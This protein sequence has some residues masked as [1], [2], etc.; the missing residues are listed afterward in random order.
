MDTQ[1]IKTAMLT[2]LQEE[3]R[4]E[5]ATDFA[6]IR[7]IPDTFVWRFLD[8]FASLTTIGQATLADA[9]AHRALGYFFP[10]AALIKFCPDNGAY[11]RYWNELLM[12]GGD[13]KYLGTRSLRSL[14]SETSG[15]T[16]PAEVLQNAR[17]IEPVKAS[18][19]RRMVKSVF[20]QTFSASATNLGGGLWRYAGV[21]HD[22]QLVVDI[23]YNGR[24]A[25]LRYWVYV[26]D[27]QRAIK[28]SRFTYQTLTGLPDSHW[29]YLD[30][31]NLDTSINLLK[32]LIIYS[33]EL[34]QRLPSE[35]KQSCGA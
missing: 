27:K 21:Y 23:D 10:P 19:I 20:S 6:V 5:Q 30:Q 29:D 25:Q 32:D 16:P 12:M 17:A 35:Y 14:L 8:Y 9:L 34:P 33:A 2:F 26:E 28:I 4:R 18:D 24:L 1:L 31:S 15:F 13:L 3:F 11:R 7:R 22:V